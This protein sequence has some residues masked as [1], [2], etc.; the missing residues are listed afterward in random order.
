MAE[1]G[2]QSCT[3]LTDDP[4]AV[5]GTVGKPARELGLKIVDETG[6]EVP[7]SSIGEV[8]SIGPSIMIG[9]Y[10]NADAS[11]RPFTPDGWFHTGDLGC[12]TDAP[13]YE[14]SAG[15]RK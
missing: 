1:A 5:C 8:L 3:L 9:Y 14:L 10:N 11:A 7:T 13:I 2:A 4:E 6:F 12:S 15:A